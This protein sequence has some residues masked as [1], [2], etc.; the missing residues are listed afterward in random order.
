MNQNTKP[1]NTLLDTCGE[2]NLITYDYA[3]SQGLIIRTFNGKVLPMKE[4]KN[5]TNKPI[6]THGI[7]TCSIIVDGIPT[8][9][10]FIVVETINNQIEALIGLPGIRKVKISILA[11]EETDQVFIGDSNIL[12]TTSTE[13]IQGDEEL[14][15]TEVRAKQKFILKPRQVLNVLKVQYDYTFFPKN[16]VLEAFF[17]PA[18]VLENS[19]IQV[20]P[21]K[22]NS[23]SRF[24][25][26]ANT[27]IDKQFIIKPGMLL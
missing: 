9:L 8:E 7:T 24:I 22:F 4:E 27:S 19:P 17:S 1:V 2:C 16:K 5:S 26:V 14:I 13:I 23:K 15:F 21:G 3:R 12:L 6:K 18:K 11:R 25:T 20:S 10:D